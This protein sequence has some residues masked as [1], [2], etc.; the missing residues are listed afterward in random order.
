MNHC[1]TNRR[2]AFSLLEL[3]IAL[4]LLGVLSALAWSILDN[5]RNAEQRGWRVA[6]RLQS[7]RSARLWLEEDLLHVCE[8]LPTPSPSL[9]S[10]SSPSLF[11]GTSTGF[12]IT[13][14][15]S[16][17]PLPW[18]EELVLNR[19]DS[20]TQE[21]AALNR[22]TRLGLYNVVAKYQ[23]QNGG[24]LTRTITSQAPLAPREPNTTSTTDIE[25][26]EPTLTVN[27]L[28]RQ[29]DRID[30]I[31]Q[32]SASLN[33]S[34]LGPLYRPR[35]RYHDGSTWKSTWTASASTSLPAAIELSYDLDAAVSTLSEG[36][37]E[38]TTPAAD[39]SE[40]LPD[41]LDDVEVP[42]VELDDDVSEA[43]LQEPRQI[44]IV[45][46]LP[47]VQVSPSSSSSA[48]LEEN[49]SFR[50]SPSNQPT[51]AEESAE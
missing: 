40:D 14:A 37:S 7:I 26:A 20:A 45:V 6:S 2:Q 8:T 50:A 46:R 17:D 19:P 43:M 25:A 47:W 38:S 27:D 22:Y 49:E 28:Y 41:P 30:Q 24:S 35:F 29:S 9:S 36:G 11:Q 16:I 51:L 21:P 48:M 13:Y 32:T 10:R 18:L 23:L 15:P 1:N 44:R 4:V 42:V 3:M 12:S 39:A 33:Q 5:F 34:Q 31:G